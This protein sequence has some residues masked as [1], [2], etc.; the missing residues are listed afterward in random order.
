[1]LKIK[2]M[3]EL[4]DYMDSTY[5]KTAEQAGIS[6]EENN[7]AVVEL[8][9]EAIREDFKLA[10]IRPE[11]VK[12]GKQL[13]DEAKSKVLI[14]T[15]IDF[16]E[17]NGGLVEKLKQAQQA[18]A[19]GADELDYVVDYQAFK[20]GCT[21][22]VKEE[23]KQGIALGLKADKVVKWIIEVAALTDTEIVKL[24]AL[25][26]NVVL[27][28]FAEKDYHRVFVKSSTGFYKTTDGKP[29]GATRKALVLMLENARP[30]PVKAAGGIRDRET[31]LEM[32][33][34]G[35]K[36]LGTSSAKTIVDGAGQTENY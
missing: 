32:I 29:N 7:K 22:Q 5:L 28:H 6:E 33:Q 18:I 17:G 31:A 3:E 20:K 34:L 27:K 30:L 10:M 14:G 26:K 25:I 2:N 9:K 35:V 36:R 4:K 1:M 16:P 13:V 15:V 19:D 12:T 23:V 11:Q 8:I 21:D 24:T